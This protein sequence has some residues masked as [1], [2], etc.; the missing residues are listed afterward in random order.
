MCVTSCTTEAVKA[1]RPQQ[2]LDAQE[3][4][5]VA[6]LVEMQFEPL[7]LPKTK[8]GHAGVKAAVRDAIGANSLFQSPAVFDKAWQR[9]RSAGRIREA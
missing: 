6:K 1:A 8:N 7:A 4:A 3:D 9:L 2:A 5:I